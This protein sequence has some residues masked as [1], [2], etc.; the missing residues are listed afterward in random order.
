MRLFEALQ[1]LLFAGAAAEA[2]PRRAPPVALP[3]V[4]EP[5]PS[6]DEPGTPEQEAREL[7][8]WLAAEGFR[9]QR[10]HGQDGVWSYYLWHCDVER[11]LPVGRIAL[12]EAWGVLDAP[13]GAD[14]APGAWI[15]RACA[16]EAAPD[17]EPWD[18]AQTLAWV[19]A[20]IKAGD[21]PTQETIRAVSGRAKQ[22]VS[23][24]LALWERRGLIPA[25][26]WAGKTKVIQAVTT[27]RRKAA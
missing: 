19:Q 6:L 5:M 4:P 7:R 18:R 11:R 25:R 2:I 15:R 24:W 10:W 9:P 8:A 16:H 3:Y 1:M 23:D 14:T 20:Q 12:R 17:P 13:S 26:R 22:T 21:H 27:P